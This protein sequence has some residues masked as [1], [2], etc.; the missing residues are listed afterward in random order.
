M[1]Q[2]IMKK[3]PKC[4]LYQLYNKNKQII[5]IGITKNINRRLNDHNRKK[6]WASE[7]NYIEVTEFISESEAMIYE[8]YQIS[9]LKPKY[10]KTALDPVSFSL[11]KLKFKEYSIKI[12]NKLPKNTS[13]LLLAIITEQNKQKVNNPKISSNK[14]NKIYK[15]NKSYLYKSIN[16]ALKDGLITRKEATYQGKV[17][18]NAYFIT[19]KGKDLIKKYI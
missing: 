6:P 4:Y 2:L 14:F 19:T 12:K 13:K 18:T 7:I 5:Y 15:I 1:I 17:K 9:N 11:P 3:H 10:N 8:T 16:S